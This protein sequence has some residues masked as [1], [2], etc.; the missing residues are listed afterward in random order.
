MSSRLPRTEA[1]FLE[2]S[3]VGAVKAKKYGADF[4]RLINMNAANPT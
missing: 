2:I 1:E 4:I 3:G